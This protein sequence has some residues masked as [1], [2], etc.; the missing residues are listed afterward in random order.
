MDTSGSME[1]GRIDL[2]KVAVQTL[3]DTFSNNDF[4]AVIPFSNTAEP[5][6]NTKLT[7]ATETFKEELLW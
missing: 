7:R 1:G 6:V 2:A 4:V 5:L 3:I